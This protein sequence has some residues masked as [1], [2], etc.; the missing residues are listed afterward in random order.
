[1]TS[2]EILKSLA[3]KVAKEALAERIKPRCLAMPMT[4]AVLA[5][6]RPCCCAI[7][8]LRGLRVRQSTAARALALPTR[9]VCKRFCLRLD[10]AVAWWLLNPARLRGFWISARFEFPPHRVAHG[11]TAPR[12]A[13]R[14]VSTLCQKGTATKASRPQSTAQSAGW[15]DSGQ[16]LRTKRATLPAC[17]R[18]ARPL[19]R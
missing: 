5:T 13:L 14:R 6:A 19:R 16:S 7:A 18:H 10:W 1:M 4:A 12:R 8:R 15:P 17:P 3:C 11:R 9:H 2:A